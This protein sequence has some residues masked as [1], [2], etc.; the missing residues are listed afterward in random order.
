[1]VEY[2][3]DSI[4][5]AIKYTQKMGKL[6]KELKANEK[7]PEIIEKKIEEKKQETTK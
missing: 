7:V 2:Y 3:Q 5:L 4:N 6:E 1:V